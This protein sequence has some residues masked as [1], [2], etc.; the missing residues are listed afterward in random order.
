MNFG[1]MSHQLAF[2]S[3]RFSSSALSEAAL[4]SSCRC[5]FVLGRC[6]DSN[7][8]HTG[9]ETITEEILKVQVASELLR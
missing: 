7:A 9:Q 4:G 8:T 1:G 2:V 5:V 6:R 3:F